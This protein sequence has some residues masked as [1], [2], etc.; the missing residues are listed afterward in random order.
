[1]KAGHDDFRRAHSS[2][3]FW[4]PRRNISY[5]ETRES[6]PKKFVIARARS[7]AREARALPGTKRRYCGVTDGEGETIS[8]VLA[9]SAC[10]R[11]RIFFSSFLDSRTLVKKGEAEV[12]GGAD[13]EVDGVAIALGLAEVALAGEFCG[14]DRSVFRSCLSNCFSAFRCPFAS[15]GRPNAGGDDVD[16]AIV[17]LT[18][19]VAEISGETEREGGGVEAGAAVAVGDADGNDV[20]LAAGRGVNVERGIAVAVCVD[21]GVDVAVAKE[22]GVAVVVAVGV[23]SG[24]ALRKGVAVAVIVAAGAAV[25]ACEDV[26]VA[27]VAAR[28]CVGFTN[29]LGGASGG[30]VASDFIFTRTLAAACLSAIAS[31]PR[32][33]TTC[34]TV[35]FTRRGRSTACPRAINGAGMT[36]ISP[37]TTDCG[38]PE[39]TSTFTCRSSR[40]RAMGCCVRVRISS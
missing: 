6:R 11:F 2:C 7:P 38:A 28:A 18:D 23:V 30:G 8:L 17:G 29:V 14:T 24:V 25:T 10:S 4:R 26:D 16:L 32:S 22:V 3:P 5:S 33:T 1:M 35:S 37:R 9:A 40:N 21:G 34:A 12:V 13:G 15:P 19:G 39:F 27:G 36:T 20:D 31:Q